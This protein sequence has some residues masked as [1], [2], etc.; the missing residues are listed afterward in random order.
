VRLV[1]ALT[2]TTSA[3]E[4]Y[5]IE[6]NSWRRVRAM[7]AALNHTVAV[8]YRGDVYVMGGYASTTGLAQEVDTLYR[9]RPKTDRW[10]RLLSA[11]STRAAHT[12]GVIG[13]RLYVA[14]GARGGFFYVFAGRAAGAGNFAVAERNDPRKRRWQRLPDMHHARGGIAAAA[15]GKKIVVFGGEEDAGTTRS[16]QVVAAARDATSTAAITG[17]TGALRPRRRS[18]EPSPCPSTPYCCS[19]RPSAR[20]G[21]P[22]TPPGRAPRSAGAPRAP[23]REAS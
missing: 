15:V 23:P 9:Y 5:D 14:G 21:P 3:V 7:P 11:P 22:A 1:V 12:M 10:A 17:C 2:L 16:A 20:Q 6:R 4:R 19:F 8:A 13:N 18:R